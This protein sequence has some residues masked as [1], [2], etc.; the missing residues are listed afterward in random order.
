MNINFESSPIFITYDATGLSSIG[1][2][3]K[4]DY[5]EELKTQAYDKLS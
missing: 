2:F 1:E 3:F 4:A 5:T